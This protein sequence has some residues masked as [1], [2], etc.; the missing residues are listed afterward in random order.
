MNKEPKM[1]EFANG[2]TFAAIAEPAPF[3][4]VLVGNNHSPV[5]SITIDKDH[6]SFDGN[7][8]ESAKA[9]VDGL[10]KEWSK[11]WKA[12]ATRILELEQQVRDLTPVIQSVKTKEDEVLE[13]IVSVLANV[14]KTPS[15][16]ELMYVN[17]HLPDEPDGAVC[18]FIQRFNLRSADQSTLVDLR[19]YIMQ[20]LGVIGSEGRNPNDSEATVIEMGRQCEK[21]LI[22][23]MYGRCNPAD[24]LL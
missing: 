8:D 24:F 15:S 5:G 12:Q 19:C 16:P 21:Y 17:Y 22:T 23:R 4:L 18:D 10:V 1:W 2:A 3:K 6:V 20:L 14:T 9:F 7:L 13:E 11:Q